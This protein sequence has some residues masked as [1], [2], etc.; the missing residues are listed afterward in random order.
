MAKKCPECGSTSLY[1]PISIM[2]KISYNGDRNRVYGVDK[3]HT[4]NIFVDG[5]TCRKCGWYGTEEE[6]NH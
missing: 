4:D 2:A 3:A 5:I 1:I 6:L